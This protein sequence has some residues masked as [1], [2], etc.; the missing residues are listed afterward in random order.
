M[1]PDPLEQPHAEDADPANAPSRT[2]FTVDDPVFKQGQERSIRRLPSLIFASVRLT[3]E[4]APRLFIL[5]TVLQLL[6]GVGVAAQLLIGKQ[7]LQ[8]LLSGHS[9]S[10]FVHALPYLIALLAVTIFLSLAQSVQ[11][12]KSKV[13]GEQITRLA[14]DRIFDVSSGVELAAYESPEFFDRLQRAKIN[15]A[16]R[17]I[18]MVTGLTATVTS[19]FTVL[20]ISAVLLRLTP[21][22]LPA[23][24]LAGLPIWVAVSRNSRS[25][26][27]FLHEM[28]KLE[29]QRYYLADTLTG[30]SEAKEVRAFG[31][32]P[33]IRTRYDDL[34]DRYL[35]GFKGLTNLRIRRSL[36]GSLASSGV[37]IVVLG[38]LGYLYVKGHVSLAAA[39]TAVAA[40]I[41]LSSQMQ[42]MMAG[43][44]NLYEGSLFL[45][46]YRSFVTFPVATPESASPPERRDAFHRLVAQ[47]VS[48][49]YPG[50]TRPALEDVSVELRRGEIVAL[51]GENGSGKT[52]LAKLLA[53][54]YAPSGGRILWDDVDV[55]S[56]DPRST[57]ASTTVV[58]QDFIHYLMSARD[59]I[60]AGYWEAMDDDGRVE[61]A[62]EQADAQRVISRLPAGYDTLLGKE[63]EGGYDLSI[64]QW[65]RIALARAFF[66]QAPFVILDEP[67]SALDPRAEKELFDRIRTLLAG[68]SVLLISHRFSSVRSA[69]RIYV[70][71]GGRLKESGDH[72]SLMAANGLYAELFT[73]QAAAYLGVEAP[74]ASSDGWSGDCSDRRWADQAD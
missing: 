33:L 16:S 29:R 50:S 2:P 34:Y 55:Q 1:T 52:T 60:T 37:T 20:G 7:V 13:M 62:A 58:F 32:A 23:A 65:Q 48:F 72:D 11:T 68:R 51:V 69:D 47:H 8:T 41:Q 74:E 10:R 73:L 15:G 53:N 4:A 40:L 39:G 38:L 25:M 44:G 28:V 5:T 26:Y 45:D 31:L 21:L 27:R 54:L 35:D 42:S 3:Y 46:D 30:R 61:A 43:V 63:F 9:S 59:N 57:R 6:S 70:L 14:F 12:E 17:P 18:Q 49:V 64:G 56:L 22:L 66:R 19:T 36:L 71:E 67:T 24:L